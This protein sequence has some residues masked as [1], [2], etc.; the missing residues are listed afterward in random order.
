[1]FPQHSAQVALHP[2]VWAHL[3]YGK[4]Y[5]LIIE[6][7]QG[8]IFASNMLPGEIYTFSLQSTATST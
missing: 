2:E 1:M 8:Q 7:I 3:K 5:S 4:F 6:T